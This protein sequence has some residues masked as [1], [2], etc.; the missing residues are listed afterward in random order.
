M[1]PGEAVAESAAAGSDEGFVGTPS[2]GGEAL[3]AEHG[4]AVA[5]GAEMLLAAGGQIGLRSAGQRVDVAVG[6]LAGEDVLAVS[7]G[8]EVPRIGE[9]APGEIAITVASA[10]LPGEEEVFGQGVGLVPCV[11]LVFGVQRGLLVTGERT[12]RQRWQGGV[13][14][15][16][17][18][19]EGVGVGGEL[20]RIK[21]AELEAFQG[22]ISSWERDHLLLKV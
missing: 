22:V 2:A 14:R 16:V 13:E 21:E 19:L 1:S 8:I 6:V 5:G 9:E 3:G 15:G 20:V 17:E 4:E 10:A 7:K 18:Y 12:G 11:G